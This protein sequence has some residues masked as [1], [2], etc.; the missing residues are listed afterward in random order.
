VTERLAWEIQIIEMWHVAAL[1]L[2]AGGNFA[3]WLK[4]R[5]ST[6]LYAYLAVEALLLVWIVAKMGK[7]VAP[8][9]ATRWGF[10]VLQYF[11]NCFLGAAFLFFAHAWARN[12][13]PARGVRIATLAV[14]A[15]FFLG[16]ATN[17]LHML[18]YSRYTFFRDD[19]GPLFYAHQTWTYLLLLAGI[20]LCASRFM[21]AFR[22]QRRQALLVAVAVLVPLAVNLLYVAGWFKPLFGFKP[23]FDITPITTM[24][25]L[26]LFAIG[27]WRYRFFDVTALAWRT[28][29]DHR[30]EGVALIGPGGHLID[31]NRT[32]TSGNPGASDLAH[33]L[34]AAPW[35]NP[36]QDAAAARNGLLKSDVDRATDGTPGERTGAA[37]DG[38]A[39]GDATEARCR[40]PDGRH[41]AV[42]WFPASRGPAS[43]GSTSHNPT[44]HNPTCHNPTSLLVRFSDETAHMRDL[45]TLAER[46]ALLTTLNAAV[47]AQVEDRRTLAVARTRN[48]LGREVHDGVGHAIVYAISLLEV[49]RRLLAAD[50]PQSRERTGQAVHFLEQAD[51][52]LREGGKTNDEKAWAW[53]SAMRAE[54]AATGRCMVFHVPDGL[55]L[56][57]GSVSETAER[58]CREAAANAVRHG[59]ASRID[60]FVRVTGGSLQINVLDDGA[61]CGPIT[62]GYGLSGLEKAV[63]RHGGELDYGPMEPHGFAVRAVLPLNGA[64]SISAMEPG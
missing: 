42:R 1:L 39:E 55:P 17:P 28:V 13:L 24:L 6:A 2:L 15:L 29:L 52:L 31:G 14:S 58:I 35:R 30:P 61:G 60:L 49:A 23:R 16:M 18:F 44:S 19:F 10:I 5:R 51:V 54:A 57:G 56:P 63:A 4:A 50:A 64:E 53:L 38:L 9:P 27:T 62:K 37:R 45:E 26:M 48:R 25:S 43:R 59:G 40:T 34:Q 7:T 11:A 46:N 36:G 33:V 47:R 12:R 20:V 41:L 32:V 3:I 22:H 21:S 8:G